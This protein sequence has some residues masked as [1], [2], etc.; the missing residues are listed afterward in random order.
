MTDMEAEMKEKMT[1]SDDDAT[2]TPASALQDNIARKG[3]NAYYFAHAHKAN[4]P[5][6]DG[7]AEPRLLKKHSSGLDGGEPAGTMKKA[8]SFLYHKSNITSYAFLNEDKVVKLFLTMEEV[9]E[10]C[11]PDD[12]TLDWDEQS[13]SLMVKNY[14]EE[15]Q[16]L[17]FGKLSGK[18]VDAS[19]KIKPNK[20]ILTLKKEKEGVEWF[21]I[22]D[23][24][25][26]D[27]EVV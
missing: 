4:G 26:P 8:P 13:F 2:P 18:I 1:V 22:N 17:S 24:G 11:S 6:W 19:F 14:K 27:H 25:A 16:C 10:K 20:I 12:I 21:T 15:D 23:K 9:G 5:Q 7:K 3:K